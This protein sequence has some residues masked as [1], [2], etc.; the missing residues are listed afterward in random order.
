MTVSNP[1]QVSAEMR[2][3]V[4][5]SSTIGNALEWF[6]FTVFGLFAGVIAKHFFPADN[7]SN[8]L[9]LTF[10]T[11]GIAF[12]ARPIGGLVFG[13]YA[14]KNGR[15]RAMIVMIMMMAVGTGLIGILPTYQAIGIAAPICVLLARLIQGF[16]AGGEFGSASAMLIEF[17]PPGRRGF[18]GSWQMVS[19]MLAFA[20]GAAF[21]FTL[22][23]RL[24]PEA[25]DSWGWRVPFILGVLIGPVGFYLRRAIDETPEFKALMATRGTVENSPLSDVLKQYPRELI[26][27]FCMIAVGTAINYVAGVY[28]TTYAVTELKL[29]LADAQFGLIVFSALNAVVVVFSGWLSDK[30]GRRNVLLPSVILYC[31]LF[32]V[33]LSRL[34]ANPTVENLYWLQATSLLLGMLAGPAPAAM[35]EIFPVR[36]RSTGVSL[37][38]NLAVMLF[39]GLAPFINTWLVQSTGNKLAPV[40]YIFFAAAVGIVG[41]VLYRE[42]PPAGLAKGDDDNRSSAPSPAGG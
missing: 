28:I 36:L 9:L 25:F 38:Y 32:Y 22:S 15:K 37:V 12:A 18:Y 21:A 14:D 23:S 16:S 10:A 33:M 27:A 26:T 5:I 19:Q 3:R 4:V 30:I 2:R 31:I 11:F 8:S 29:K 6:D 35:S 24:S 13:I 40:F 7:P 42:P 20:I 17:A 41:F 1:P 39:G 34:V